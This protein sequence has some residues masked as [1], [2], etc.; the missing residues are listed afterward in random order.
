MG[1]ELDWDTVYSNL[2]NYIKFASKQVAEQYQTGVVNSAED[3][4]QEGQLLLYHCY[5]LYKYK[6]LNQF[7]ALFKASLWRKLRGLG[8]KKEFLVVDITEAYDLGYSETVVDDMYEEYKLQQVVEILSADDIAI[9][10]LKEMITPS[11]RTLWEA[12]MDVARKQM[13]KDQNYNVSVPSSVTVKGV[14]IQRGME[15]TKAKYKETLN[16]IKN[17]VSIVYNIAD[18]NPVSDDDEETLE[19]IKNQLLVG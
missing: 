1:E 3:L 14:H 19:N 17:V 11:E 4:F 2:V 8:A 15:I 18:G 9:T 5:N 6:P 12:K 16:T 13:I 7:N 10:I